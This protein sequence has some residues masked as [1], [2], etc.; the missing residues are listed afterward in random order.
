MTDHV[1]ELLGAAN[2][3]GGGPESRVDAWSETSGRLT[4][5][6]P[7][8]PR[9]SGQLEQCRR[10]TIPCLYPTWTVMSAFAV[11]EVVSLRDHRTADAFIRA[12]G[13]KRPSRGRKIRC[14]WL[15]SL[16]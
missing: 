10:V 2:R 11:E 6:E 5:E 9:R 13:E 14:Q 12:S 8:D 15:R 4:R 16:H 1:E 3:C 7:D